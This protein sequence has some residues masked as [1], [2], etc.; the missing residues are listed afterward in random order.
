MGGLGNGGGEAVGG[1]IWAKVVL[2]WLEEFGEVGGAA[3]GEE[4]DD[5]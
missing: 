5:S 3:G 2:M 4:A 1:Y